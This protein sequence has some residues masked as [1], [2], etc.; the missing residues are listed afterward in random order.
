M[1]HG[2][3]SGSVGIGGSGGSGSGGVAPP[4]NSSGQKVMFKNN[5]N[6]SS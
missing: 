2:G 3:E 5:H 1:A 6:S 4:Q